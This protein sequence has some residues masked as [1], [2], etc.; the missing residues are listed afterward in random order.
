MGFFERN[1][2]EECWNEDTTETVDHYLM[3]CHGMQ[4]K[5]YR[6]L[7]RKNYLILINVETN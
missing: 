3:E 5:F 6:D 1:W 7:N 2:C 4:N